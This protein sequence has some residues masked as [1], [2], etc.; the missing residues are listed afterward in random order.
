M[1][2]LLYVIV[3]SLLAFLALGSGLAKLNGIPEVKQLLEHVGATRFG[4][5]LGYVEILGS[6]GLVVGNFVALVGMAA[7]FGLSVFYTG[8]IFAHIRVKDAWSKWANPALPLALG[9]GALA[10]RAV[11][12]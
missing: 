9:I 7:A 4:R 3:S 11:T 12:V 2:F 6:V 8:A 5:Q 1:V 10:L